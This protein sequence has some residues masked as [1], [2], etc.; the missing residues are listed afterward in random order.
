LQ[1]EASNNDRSYTYKEIHDN[2]ILC[3]SA[4]NKLGISKGDVVVNCC[5]NCAAYAVIITATAACG[6]ILST[7]NP[8]YTKG[9]EIKS[10]AWNLNAAAT[11]I[12]CTSC[13]SESTKYENSEVSL[14]EAE[15]YLYGIAAMYL[16]MK[17]V[18]VLAMKR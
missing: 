5:G 14:L 9:N 16:E 2:I 13:D 1:I 3:A 18:S 17:G 10:C 12:Q 7:C 15:F 6:G 11:V 8:T 4:L